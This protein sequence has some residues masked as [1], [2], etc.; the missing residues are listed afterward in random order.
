MM[1]FTLVPIQQQ[2]RASPQYLKP[3][4]VQKAGFKASACKTGVV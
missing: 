4:G 2:M 1:S 3:E